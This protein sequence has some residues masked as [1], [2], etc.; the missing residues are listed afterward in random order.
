MKIKLPIEKIR[1]FLA[2]SKY[3]V[4]PPDRSNINP[5]IKFIKVEIVFGTCILTKTNNNSFCKFSFD[6][7]EEDVEFLIQEENLSSFCTDS[8]H[9][10]LTLN[11][12]DGF[13]KMSDGYFKRKVN[14]NGVGVIDF[15]LIPKQED[16]LIRL[17]R[18]VLTSLIPAKA[19]IGSDK[20]MTPFQSAYLSGNDVYSSA[21]QTM[22]IRSFK[23]QLPTI[24]ITP[25]ECLLLSSFEYVDYCKS[26]NYNTYIHKN[27]VYGFIQP[28][29]ATGFD[30]K[31][32]IGRLT[33][34]NY[35]TI[36]VEDMINFCN[37]TMRFTQGL[38]CNSTLST[39][40]TEFGAIANLLFEDR[41]KNEE[42]TIDVPIK[43]V[44]D[45]FSFNFSPDIW[46]PILKVLPYEEICIGDEIGLVSIWN[47]IDKNYN[48]IISKVNL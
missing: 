2:I 43:L 37:S 48:G 47:E 7:S 32:Q 13:I 44:G 41:S 26:D 4:L 11:M 29:G 18:E 46:L 17:E 15:P 20:I 31:A 30:Y 1:E 16:K 39:E 3:I 8:K 22:Y 21:M 25:A 42:N 19:H 35:L 9:E 27:I 5:I 6:V 45:N 34:K 40:K 24:A 28:H 23:A 10:E 14:V 36:K 12:Q 33:K 38:F